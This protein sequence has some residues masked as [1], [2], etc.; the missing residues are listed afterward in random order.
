ME[1]RQCR[2]TVVQLQ[3]CEVQTHEVLAG[4]EASYWLH[5]GH[6]WQQRCLT[7]SVF[8]DLLILVRHLPEDAREPVR[9][10]VLAARAEW[11]QGGLRHG[12][13]RPLP[14]G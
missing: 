9:S 1:C 12:D 5:N 4:D 8:C 6:W 11:L 2:R 3:W 10:A 14:G 13:Q 7:C